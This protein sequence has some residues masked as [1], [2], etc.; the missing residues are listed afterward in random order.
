MTIAA[1]S[2][3]TAASTTSTQTR[4]STPTAISSIPAPSP[5]HKP[6][7]S[8]TPTPSS[9]ASSPPRASPTLLPTPTTARRK[10]RRIN[11]TQPPT[12]KL[13]Q[14]HL[15]LGQAP[16]R[17]SCPICHMSYDPSLPEDTLLHKKFHAKSTGGVDFISSCPRILWSGVG[18]VQD[19]WEERERELVIVVG[20]DSN[21]LE[22][23]RVMEVMEIVERELGCQEIKEEEVF[24]V[25]KYDAKG[26]R[27]R[28]RSGDEGGR[29]KVFLYLLGR[30]CV[31]LLLAERIEKAYKITLPPFQSPASTSISPSSATPPAPII[32]N[33][34][35]PLPPPLPD[36]PLTLSPTTS[37]ALL[38]ISR[39][40]TCSAHRRRGIA[41]RLLD[42][43]RQAFIYGMTIDKSRV[44]FSQ[45]TAL[46]KALAGEWFLREGGWLVYLDENCA[47]G[48]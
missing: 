39:I 31:G 34:P 5:L 4:T 3:T 43:A 9:A 7:P 48:G 42:V 11:P 8:L 37:P 41:T 30:K 32:P 26:R 13:T 2:H 12:K 23:R 28:D 38:G 33:D 24:G 36:H 20:R 46:G 18:F 21:K 45:P 25:P 6:K 10:K 14:L 19:A 16:A 17:T 35:C 27:G 1:T 40:W 44:A 15:D 22:R 47:P 29:Y